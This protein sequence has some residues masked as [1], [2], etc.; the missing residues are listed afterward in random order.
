[1]LHP[2]HILNSLIYASGIDNFRLKNKPSLLQPVNI[3]LPKT[4]RRIN[5]PRQAEILLQNRRRRFR[6][7][8]RRH[9]TKL[10]FQPQQNKA[11]AKRKKDSH[12]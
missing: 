1:M 8:N 3:R 2:V 5:P 10:A 9:Y 6:D 7:Q 11:G 12:L 4:R